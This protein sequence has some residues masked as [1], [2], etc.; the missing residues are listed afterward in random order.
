MSSK[1]GCLGY[2]YYNTV[3]YKWNIVK[4]GLCKK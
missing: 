3:R 2:E 4:Y 1:I